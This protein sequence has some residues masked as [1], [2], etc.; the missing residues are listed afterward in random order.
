MSVEV[1]MPVRMRHN[2]SASEREQVLAFLG[3][4]SKVGMGRFDDHLLAD[5]T[6]GPRE[7]FLAAIAMRV[8][9]TIAGYAQAS[10]ANDGLTVGCVTDGDDA[11]IV[12]LLRELLAALPSDVPITWWGSDDTRSVAAELGMVPGRRL[13]NMHVALPVT[14][15][16]DVHVRPFRVGAD[17]AAWLQ[18]NNAAFEWHG[19]QGGW[20]AATLQQRESEPWFDPSGFLLHERNG[21]LAAFCWTKLHGDTRG[22]HHHLIGEIYVIAVH[23]E[24]HG[25]GLGRALTVAGLQHL[26]AVRATSAMLYVDADNVAAVRLY[27]HL[28]FT[29]THAAQA[30]QRQAHPTSPAE[31]PRS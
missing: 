26:H 6:H 16:T 13:L 21:R 5:L 29:V 27:R 31:G 25:L 11:A 4:A 15:T 1:P 30:Y 20:D 9:G 28:G 23:P 8:D 22:A 19:E 3:T 12:N 2:L 18:V 24:F 7:G 17:E 14:S 10:A